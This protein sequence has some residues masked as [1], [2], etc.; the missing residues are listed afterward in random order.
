M[1]FLILWGAALT[2][3]VATDIVPAQDHGEAGRHA[4][5]DAGERPAHP[6]PEVPP[7]RIGEAIQDFTLNDSEGRP[8]RL[9]DLRRSASSPGTIAV[10]TFWCTTCTSCRMMERGFDQKVREYSGK[11]VRFLMVASNATETADPV[12][13]FLEN[14]GVRF[15]VLMDA[16]SRVARLFDA[17]FTTTTAVIDAN[18][19]LRYWGAF[20]WAEAAVKDLLAGRDVAMPQSVPNG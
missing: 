16:G 2:A 3:L 5:H 8:F 18:G 11:G 6:A 13:R 9:S 7:S 14:R 19:R 1:K 17:R 12:N 15:P 4:G 10:L 20:R